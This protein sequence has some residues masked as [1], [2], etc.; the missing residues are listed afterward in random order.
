MSKRSRGELLIFLQSLFQVN[1]KCPSESP[2]NCGHIHVAE[3]C[4]CSH[5]PQP[6]PYRPHCSAPLSHAKSASSSSLLPRGLFWSS[7]GPHCPLPGH[8]PPPLICL[9]C[10]TVPATLALHFRSMGMPATALTFFPLL[11]CGVVSPFLISK[12]CQI[13]KTDTQHP[14]LSTLMLFATDFFL[15]THNQRFQIQ[16]KP[17]CALS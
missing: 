8:L 1:T 17:F 14:K 16:L 15:K 11:L 9:L 2:C 3:P 12:I 4:L 7:R 13:Y 10:P 5:L 6:H